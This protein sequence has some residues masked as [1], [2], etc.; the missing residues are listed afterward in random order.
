MT[1]AA[2]RSGIDKR[3]TC[4]VAT[5]LLERGHDIRTASLRSNDILE[6]CQRFRDDVPIPYQESNNP[7]R[8]ACGGS[9]YVAET[10]RFPQPS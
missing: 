1:E 6:P 8:T 5:H 4:P 9:C 3:A 7:T 10:A 2:A